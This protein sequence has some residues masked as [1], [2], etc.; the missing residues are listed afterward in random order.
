MPSAD[1]LVQLATAA[2]EEQDAGV[3]ARVVDLQGFGS[4][5]AGELLIVPADPLRPTVGSL[6]GGVLTERVRDAQA[7]FL[8]EVP[9]GDAEAV[10]AG[11][12]CGGSA[13]V[14][15]QPLSSVPKD[16]WAA[17]IDRRPISLVVEVG[18]VAGELRCRTVGAPHLGR[19][20]SEAGAD[21]VVEKA[22]QLLRGRER[23]TVFTSGDVE[24]FIEAFRPVP[25]LLV[26]GRAALA[27]ALLAQGRLLGWTGEVV[28]EQTDDLVERCRALGQV[29]AFVALSHDLDAS[30]AALAAALTGGCGYIGALGSRHTQGARAERLSADHGIGP[31]LLAKVHGPVGLDVGSRT[32]E[33][34][35]V[36]VVAEYLAHRSGRSGASLARSAGSI[37]G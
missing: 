31:E 37:N 3:L 11:L 7:P 28:D 34:T 21:I 5:R 27:D 36:A 13:R 9:V 32:P 25:H 18:P 10:A 17:L 23:T 15:V 14:L 12:A 35:A 20:G 8:F 6:L 4:R 19:T 22:E 2:L 29:D 33:E 26:L 24:I 16:F 30:C 1:A